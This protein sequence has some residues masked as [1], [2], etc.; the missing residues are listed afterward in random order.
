MTPD[1][2]YQWND[3]N[4]ELVAYMRTDLSPGVEAEVRRVT[5]AALELWRRERQAAEQQ[6]QKV[7]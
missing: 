7:T 2:I 3:E 6:A 1:F 4:T 5:A